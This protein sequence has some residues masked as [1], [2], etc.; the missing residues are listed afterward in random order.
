VRKAA[1]CPVLLVLAFGCGPSYSDL[2]KK[3]P[4]IEARLKLIE[5]VGA[6]IPALDTAPE[7]FEAVSP[8]PIF[9]PANGRE[10]AVA[11]DY[12]DL[13]DLAGRAEATHL[14][15]DD[16]VRDVASWA[17]KGT[18]ADGQKP[19]GD[20]LS[21]FEDK[22][23]RILAARYVLILR[24]MGG[25]D[26]QSNGGATFTGGQWRGEAWF[27]DLDQQKLLGR[28]RFEARNSGSVQA[29]ARNQSLYLLNDLRDNALRLVQ[30]EF[31]KRYPGGTPPFWGNLH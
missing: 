31:K 27:F 21:M 29:D 22:I 18:K 25:V 19:A 2:Q 7:G 14:V 30:E 23:N 28:L 26:F 15:T 11:V 8:P 24:T 16:Y 5:S 9:P 17:R 13:K 4:A 10:N 6:K 20:L 12:T 1:L 3:N